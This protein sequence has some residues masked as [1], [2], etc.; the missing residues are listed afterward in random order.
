MS[1]H[2]GSPGQWRRGWEA[3]VEGWDCEHQGHGVFA[4]S[5]QRSNKRR[6][7]V[8]GEF[9]AGR[10]ERLEF[11]QIRVDSFCSLA[12][13]LWYRKRHLVCGQ[14]TADKDKGWWEGGNKRLAE[15]RRH[16]LCLKA[17]G[18]QLDS[19]RALPF[20]QDTFLPQ[21][22]LRSEPCLTQQGRRTAPKVLIIGI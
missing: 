1:G 14:R 19:V 7:W 13:A 16:C 12:A 5:L 17:V 11:W 8:N 18:C 9:R 4:V 2:R 15:R 10:R 21:L 20:S 3:C 22:S 6:G